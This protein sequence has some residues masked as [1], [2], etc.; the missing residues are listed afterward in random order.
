MTPLST[1]CDLALEL[2]HCTPR[3]YYARTTE[4]ER[5]LIKVHLAYRQK[6]HAMAEK[7]AQARARQPRLP[8]GL[9]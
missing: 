6:Q 8:E 5:M 1:D 3:E 4:A 2:L 9:Y 7:L